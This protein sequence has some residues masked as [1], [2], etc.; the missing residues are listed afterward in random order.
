M[1]VTAVRLGFSVRCCLSLEGALL[2]GALAAGPAGLVVRLLLTLVA[3][4]FLVRP[5]L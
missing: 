3:F 2:L 5:A 1:P 4:N